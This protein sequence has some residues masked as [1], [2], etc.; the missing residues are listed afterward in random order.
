[1]ANF[2]FAGAHIQQSWVSF[3]GVS[4]LVMTDSQFIRTRVFVK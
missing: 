4:F 1:M 2:E 3:S